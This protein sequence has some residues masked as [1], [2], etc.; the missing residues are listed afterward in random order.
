M[1]PVLLY[2]SLLAVPSGSDRP[3]TEA[4][5]PQARALFDGKSLEGWVVEGARE[6]KV[7]DQMQPI[8]V[9]RE[10]M[11]SC[12]VP[13]GSFGFLRYS[14]QEFTDFHLK[15]EYR[16]QAPEKKGARKGNSGVG[17]R[18]VAFDPKRS[19]ATRPSFASYEI[20][21]LDDAGGQP[22][23]HCTA[24]LYRYVAP[25]ELP[26][27]PA[28]Q[29][30]TLEVECVGPRIKIRLNDKLVV[31]VDQSTIEALKNKP[32]K[33]YVCLQNHGSRVDFRNLTLRE[34]QAKAAQDK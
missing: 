28:P 23:K 2:A 18:T 16:F 4:P 26:N 15:L 24:S 34:I 11:I 32:L 22:D 17:I 1:L 21:L 19:T 3:A 27:K 14:K 33:G 20:Q 31:D 12:M 5:Q 10:G 13:Q 25:K 30:N 7:G 29:W 6:F 9:A 8:W